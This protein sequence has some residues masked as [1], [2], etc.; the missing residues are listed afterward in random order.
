[1]SRNDG[2]KIEIKYDTSSCTEINK[3]KAKGHGH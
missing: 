3:V 1:M 2:L